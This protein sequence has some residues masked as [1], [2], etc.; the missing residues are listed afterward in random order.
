VNKDWSK[1]DRDAGEHAALSKVA[2]ESVVGIA[3]G[4]VVVFVV[5]VGLDWLATPAHRRGGDFWA[6][7]SGEIK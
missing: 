3:L 6:G 7:W 5:D 1:V 2:A 4:G